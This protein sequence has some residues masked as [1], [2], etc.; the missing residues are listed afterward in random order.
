MRIG[1]VIGNP[2]GYSDSVSALTSAYDRA[3]AEG[4]SAVWMTQH[5]GFDALD[6]DGVV[7]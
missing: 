1:V 2:G 4:L 7:G 5:A 3:R 6:L